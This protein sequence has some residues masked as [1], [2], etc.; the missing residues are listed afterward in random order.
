MPNIQLDSIDLKILKILQEDADISNVSLA[1]RVGLSPSPCL[2]RVRIL[3]EAGIIKKRVTL[4]DASALGLHVSVFVLVQLE[5]Q[6]KEQLAAFETEIRKRAEVV[7]C[8]LM[9]GESDYLLRVLVPDLATYERFLKDSLTRI[10]GVANI[11]SSFALQQVSYSTA[12]P[13]VHLQ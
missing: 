9:T 11:R 4:L 1:D 13:L 7:E 12:L 8:Y 2:R 10:E 6:I 3:E 5:R